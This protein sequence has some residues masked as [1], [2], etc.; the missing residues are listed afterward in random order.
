MIKFKKFFKNL[1]TYVLLFSLIIQNSLVYSKINDFTFSNNNIK[2]NVNFLVKDLIIG[3][4]TGRVCDYFD[5]IGSKAKVIIIKDLH[6]NEESQKNIYKI[7]EEIN[8]EYS[9]NNYLFDDILIEG[10][11]SDLKTST[12]LQFLRALPNGF[13]KSFILEDTFLKDKFSGAEKFVINNLDKNLLG[14]EEENAYKDNLSYFIN[15]TEKE[16]LNY[17]LIRLINSYI[18]LKNIKIYSKD[19]EKLDKLV[20]DY[21][22]NKISI[23]EY[24]DRLKS[25]VTFFD[26]NKEIPNLLKNYEYA[27][28]LANLQSDKTIMVEAL[29]MERILFSKLSRKEFLKISELGN[30]KNRDYTEYYLYLQKLI[31]KN[32][33]GILLNKNFNNLSMYFDYLNKLSS[34]DVN[35]VYS[36]ESNLIYRISN[37]LAIDDNEKKFLKLGRVLTLFHKFINNSAIASEVKEIDE[38]IEEYINIFRAFAME[39]IKDFLSFK[40]VLDTCKKLEEKIYG[41]RNFYKIAEKRNFIFANKIQNILEKKNNSSE[42]IAILPVVVGGYHASSIASLLKEKNIPYIVV[43]PNVS[44]LQDSA[45]YDEKISTQADIWQNLSTLALVTHFENHIY[46]SNE[47]EEKFKVM[48]KKEKKQLINNLARNIIN[49]T[50]IDWTKNLTEINEILEDK[51]KDNLVL[52]KKIA[53]FFKDKVDERIK[54]NKKEEIEKQEKNF[55]EQIDKENK[56]SVDKILMSTDPEKEN[57][58]DL[59]DIEK[60]PQL[61]KYITQYKDTYKNELN[62][63]KENIK[64]GKDKV[65]NADIEEQ[66]QKLVNSFPYVCSDLILEGDI[67]IKNNFKVFL[68]LDVDIDKQKQINE[69]ISSKLKEKFKDNRELKEEDIN[70]I[71]SLKDVSD[72]LQNQIQFKIFK[73]WCLKFFNR[74]KKEINDFSF[75]SDNNLKFSEIIKKVFK[76]KMKIGA[77]EKSIKKRI[78]ESTSEKLAKDIVSNDKNNSLKDLQEEIFI[79][80]KNLSQTLHSS[81]VMDKNISNFFEIFKDMSDN[82]KK[83][84]SVLTNPSILEIKDLFLTNNELE[85]KKMLFKNIKI[86]DKKYKVIFDICKNILESCQ[87]EKEGKKEFNEENFRNKFKHFDISDLLNF[88]F[89]FSKEIE[90]ERAETLYKYFTNLLKKDELNKEK[91]SFI[92]SLR[93]EKG[94]NLDDKIKEEIKRSTREK[95]GKEYIDFLNRN[96]ENILIKNKKK[97]IETYKKSRTEYN[98]ILNRIEKRKK[99]EQKLNDLKD[100]DI[101]KDIKKS[102]NYDLA[103]SKVKKENKK[104]EEIKEEDAFNIKTIITKNLNKDMENEKHMTKIKT[105]E[106]NSKNDDDDVLKKNLYNKEDDVSKLTLDHLISLDYINND[107]KKETENIILNLKNEMNV[108]DFQLDVKEDDLKSAIQLENFL[109][110]RKKIEILFNYMNDD[111]KK[112]VLA[113]LNLMEDKKSVKIDLNKLDKNHNLSLL[114]FDA[115]TLNEFL[116]PAICIAMFNKKNIKINQKFLFLNSLKNNLKNI[117]KENSFLGSQLG[118]KVKYNDK[119]EKFL[120]DL[121]NNTEIEIYDENQKK[122]DKLIEKFK[123][124][125]KNFSKDKQKDIEDKII[126]K[127][128]FLSI[129]T[130]DIDEMKAYVDLLNKNINM[131]FLLKDISFTDEEDLSNKLKN[132]FSSL[133]EKLKKEKNKEIDDINEYLDFYVKQEELLSEQ[134]LTEKDIEENR[135]DFNTKKEAIEKKQR[136]M[137]EECLKIYSEIENY[138]NIILKNTDSN[139]SQF[140]ANIIKL[141][142]KATLKT[143]E[144]YKIKLELDNLSLAEKDINKHEEELN[145]LKDIENNMK[146]EIFDK[147]TSKLD[148][149]LT[150]ALDKLQKKKELNEDKN[151]E[152]IEQ[153]KYDELLNS[154]SLAVLKVE[155]DFTQE[156]YNDAVEKVDKL[157][158]EDDSG[159]EENK[160]KNNIKLKLRQN[161]LELRRRLTILAYDMKIFDINKLKEK[162][163]DIQKDIDDI[164]GKLLAKID[165]EDIKQK[166]EEIKRKDNKIKELKTKYGVKDEDTKDSLEKE[167]LDLKSQFEEIKRKEINDIEEEIEKIKTQY[168]KDINVIKAEALFSVDKEINIL[169]KIT[170]FDD[171]KDTI[172]EIK[173][174]LESYR[175]AIA[176]Y[177]NYKKI[178]EEE[179]KDPSLISENSDEL[180][181]SIEEIND[182]FNNLESAEDKKNEEDKNTDKKAENGLENEIKKIEEDEIKRKINKD[183]YEKIKDMIKQKLEVINSDVKNI[184]NVIKTAIKKEKDKENLKKLNEYFKKLEAIEKVKIVFNP[185]EVLDVFLK[186][187]Q[188]MKVNIGA[189]IGEDN[190]KISKKSA[191]LLKNKEFK[192]LLKLENRNLLFSVNKLND[193]SVLNRIKSLN[194]EKEK[195]KGSADFINI[196][197]TKENIKKSIEGIEKQLEKE[198]GGKNIKKEDS[199]IEKMKKAI[200]ELKRKQQKYIESKIEKENQKIK[201]EGKI[202]ALENEN[203]NIEKKEQDIETKKTKME[204]DLD[205]KKKKLDDLNKEIMNLDKDKEDSENELKEIKE[206]SSNL[207]KLENEFKNKQSELEKELEKLSYLEAEK[208]DLDKQKEEYKKSIDELIK[209]RNELEAKLQEIKDSLVKCEKLKEIKEK[210]NKKL[211]LEKKIDD[212]KGKIENIKNENKDLD[213]TDNLQKKYDEIK[214]EKD[215]LYK[216]KKMIKDEIQSMAD[217]DMDRLRQ[218][219]KQKKIWEKDLEEYNLLKEKV[220]DKGG[221]EGLEKDIDVLNDRDKDDSYESILKYFNDLYNEEYHNNGYDFR[222]YL[223]IMNDYLYKFY[224]WR[225]SLKNKN[226]AEYKQFIVDKKKDNSF[227][228][229]DKALEYSEKWL[230]LIRKHEGSS[231]ESKMKF[232]YMG[233]KKQFTWTK[234][235]KFDLTNGKYDK[236][237]TNSAINLINNFFN[238]VLGKDEKENENYEKISTLYAQLKDFNDKY[239][240]SYLGQSLRNIIDRGKDAEES[241][242]D[243]DKELT[244]LQNKLK[245]KQEK[246]KELE[247]IE[248]QEKK[249]TEELDKIEKSLKI[250]KELETLNKSKND[251]EKDLELYKLTNEEQTFLHE[252]E[253][254]D[255]SKL[256]SDYE[257]FDVELKNLLIELEK[258]E[259]NYQIIINKYNKNSLDIEETEKRIEILLKRKLEIEDK[260]EDLK[261]KFKNSDFEDMSKV[262][263]EGEGSLDKKKERITALKKDRTILE[264]EIQDLDSQKK[265]L[266]NKLTEYT[267]TKEKNSQKEKEEEENLETIKKELLDNERELNRI[268][269]SIEK[270]IIAKFRAEAFVKQKKGEL[271]SQKQLLDILLKI[272]R[273]NNK[274]TILEEIDKIKE[275]KQEI[276]KDL[277][278]NHGEISALNDKKEKYEKEKENL[279]NQI[280]E[281]ELENGNYENNI[282]REDGARMKLDLA[283]DMI[284][285]N[286]FENDIND[287][288]KKDS[289]RGFLNVQAEDGLKEYIKEDISEENTEE[290]SDIVEE[291]EHYAA[292][293]GKVNKKLFS[294]TSYKKTGFSNIFDEAKKGLNEILKCQT[295]LFEGINLKNVAQTINRMRL[296]EYGVVDTSGFDIASKD[297]LNMENIDVTI[298][299]T[300]QMEA[301]LLLLGEKGLNTREIYKENFMH[302]ILELAFQKEKIKQEVSHDKVLNSLGNFQ[303]LVSNLAD[304]DTLNGM[305]D[306]LRR[307]GIDIKD[308]KELEK[309]II[310][311]MPFDM[312]M[313]DSLYFDEMMSSFNEKLKIKNNAKL[314]LDE[315]IEK[316]RMEKFNSIVRKNRLEMKN[317]LKTIGVHSS[318]LY[319]TTTT[320][321]PFP[322]KIQFQ[323]KKDIVSIIKSVLDNSDKKDERGNKNIKL[324]ITESDLEKPFMYKNGQWITSKKNLELINAMQYLTNELY[325]VDLV[326]D[327]IKKEDSFNDLKSNISKF[328]SFE[329]REFLVENI[330]NSE[331]ARNL[332]NIFP[333]CKRF[334]EYKYLDKKQNSLSANEI[335][336]YNSRKKEFY[337]KD[338]NTLIDEAIYSSI[339]NKLSDSRFEKYNTIFNFIS[340]IYDMKINKRF[341]SIASIEDFLNYLENTDLS[342]LMGEKELDYQTKTDILARFEELMKYM[343]EDEAKM[344]EEEAQEIIIDIASSENINLSEYVNKKLKENGIHK[345]ED[346]QNKNIVI[347]GDTPEL[348]S[349]DERKSNA[350]FSQMQMLLNKITRLGG[351]IAYI[352]SFELIAEIVNKK[353]DNVIIKDMIEKGFLKISHY[354]PN[355]RGVVMAPNTIVDKEIVKLAE[356]IYGK[357]KFNSNKEKLIDELLNIEFRIRMN[358]DVDEKIEKALNI[359]ISNMING[360]FS[361]FNTQK[362]KYSKDEID[363]I[364]KE[365][366]IRQFVLMSGNFDEYKCFSNV[367]PSPYESKVEIVV[368]SAETGINIIKFKDDG[369]LQINTN[370]SDIMPSIATTT[371]LESLSKAEKI[372]MKIKYSFNKMYRKYIRSI[373]K[374]MFPQIK[375]ND[376]KKNENL[377]RSELLRGMLASA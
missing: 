223:Y 14:I 373:L 15:F 320:F 20:V 141:R 219:E 305:V 303:K 236:Y 2:T 222:E 227:K 41:M 101:K 8:K 276:Q 92:F 35:A 167:L 40:L 341:F 53:K 337:G 360:T 152:N 132:F 330:E 218:L 214:K 202:E 293:M 247:N 365:N 267:K 159:F 66:F 254:L 91:N 100:I 146:L 130:K 354:F 290:K 232:I 338:F 366:Q 99:E 235:L 288:Y 47:I 162:M 171:N 49:D 300:K 203:K 45:I 314:P 68:K 197:V 295:K 166:Q 31:N 244:E 97:D 61:N 287:V 55:K 85:V 294:S 200:E 266:D 250:S 291:E 255:E 137:E 58:N 342:F 77:E 104:E 225:K 333:L 5:Q 306:I 145:I 343:L 143:E 210:K 273:Q 80:M 25:F 271:E 327:L 60:L 118:D 339:D 3:M 185:E 277:E 34:L 39:N 59:D 340:N 220:K 348:V 134:N 165:N 322:D 180:N 90:N 168:E 7:L 319:Q 33:Y 328:Y 186:L 284:R 240:F 361:I 147:L 312:S 292:I 344:I 86:D 114:S 279:K 243:F 163:T 164:K 195:I 63:K 122:V 94:E 98:K 151:K 336:L 71:F 108:E 44:S 27:K 161:Q 308:R 352:P 329:D 115:S 310:R 158:I 1:I 107:F 345:E 260:R 331:I 350:S 245:L 188:E 129:N 289:Y 242:K 377:Y 123:D 48:S 358:L 70:Y 173:N 215:S 172:N 28:K 148:V 19:I 368:P 38:N 10:A 119:L 78:L 136:K 84:L 217:I 283:I 29:T 318:S 182:T 297:E 364:L 191:E 149:V 93:K 175:P 111:D 298:R 170:L 113:I 36:E 286:A 359:S 307:N 102:K 190:I 13:L 131:L 246:E 325:L 150:L 228:N 199:K 96:S 103:E 346:F 367:N 157:K 212:I 140:R 23:I 154:A 16:K 110:N 349:D 269:N 201:S 120:D 133:Q 42:K 11:W 57:S 253:G 73:L 324:V 30:N 43:S 4:D 153:K 198:E 302:E 252:N 256:R 363:E 270:Y 160:D 311:Y 282:S 139:N 207:T 374:E 206:F 194:R 226:E 125:I 12:D 88:E 83:I 326:G 347:R 127:L 281:K 304:S 106:L 213:T 229:L 221:I 369:K 257:I 313:D 370:V 216:S 376:Y 116:L 64:Q 356:N 335:N 72:T 332:T 155:K 52:S 323:I 144:L 46:S 87:E 192:K 79:E 353:G 17:L 211:A 22:K 299:V 26:L 187:I 265:D 248:E 196:D 9:S 317:N 176:S 362:Q 6:C 272:E 89:E 261:N 138:E 67:D 205:E 74:L 263:N 233:S 174:D 51:F 351:K 193:P 184:S 231:F 355:V 371:T 241:L 117:A 178:K 234:Y 189:I 278:T 81:A 142:E 237:A 128:Q 259:K 109:E 251:L 135:K 309:G 264:K 249:K 76:N 262:I 375:K 315:K 208:A 62:K 169:E 268:K 105:D 204:T 50:S 112:D 238:T 275:E 177:E 65:V 32:G 179:K 18:T 21:R 321:Y 274:I 156:N 280:E 296:K 334:Q 56:K 357:E 37:V 209:R 126:T 258:K 121:L 69:E 301:L 54:K 239:G 124:K 75:F 316:I 224:Q 24:V 285:L 82:D 181:A 230:N 183:I 95:V 372:S